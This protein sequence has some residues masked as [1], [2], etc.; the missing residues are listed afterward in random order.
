MSAALALNVTA[1]AEAPARIRMLGGSHLPE[2]LRKLT[3]MDQVPKGHLVLKDW[4]LGGAFVVIDPADKAMVHGETFA[5]QWSEHRPPSTNE[6]RWYDAKNGRP[7]RWMI[8]TPF[9]PDG[10]LAMGDNTNP[11]SF[12]RAVVGKVVGILCNRDGTPMVQ[13]WAEEYDTKPDALDPATL[14][15]S[16]AMKCE[17]DCLMPVYP[18]GTKF[19]LSTTDRRRVGDFVALWRKP[20]LTGSKQYQSLMKRLLT[21]IPRRWTSKHRDMPPVILVET[22]NPKRTWVVPMDQLAAVHRCIG[23]YDGPT[24]PAEGV[25]Q[26][27]PA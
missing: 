24:H 12:A 11:A 9:V 4:H 5:I 23:Q 22:L 17:G 13:L 3:H 21:P 10:F 15:E 7:S 20:E 14:P 2:A 8:R 25:R 19:L 16:Y 27:V 6:I 26:A 1:Q 18:T